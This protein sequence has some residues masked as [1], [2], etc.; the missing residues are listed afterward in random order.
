MSRT[1]FNKFTKFS[2]SS[3]FGFGFGI[4]IIIERG[5]KIEKS[6][7][8]KMYNFYSSFLI[9][10]KF[11]PDITHHLESERRRFS[12]NS[13]KKVVF[14]AWH[15]PKIPNFHFHSTAVYLLPN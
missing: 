14:K 3:I 10:F 2:A 9:N 13:K 6:Q 15:K 12:K 7:T 8:L 5:F 1:F 11:L 4:E